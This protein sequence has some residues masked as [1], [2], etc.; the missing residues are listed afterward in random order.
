MT[1]KKISTKTTTTEIALPP[2]IIKADLVRPSWKSKTKMATEDGSKYGNRIEFDLWYTERFG[3]CIPTL[4]IS[5]RRTRVNQ[6]YSGGE[7]TYAVSVKTKETVTCGNGPHIKA[8]HTVY[9]KESRLAA[10]QQ[11]IDLRE[12]GSERANTIRDSISTRRANTAARR[13]T[14][15]GW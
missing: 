9:V 4:L 5:K 14:F 1:T 12:L 13:S 6:S 2:G 10:L 11:F 15:G 3:W 8:R 7:R